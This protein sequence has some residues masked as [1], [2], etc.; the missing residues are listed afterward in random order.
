M[1]D[2]QV[3]DLNLAG[4][5]DIICPLL[6]GVEKVYHPTTRLLTIL[7]LL[8][9]RPILSGAELAQR[10]DVEPRTIRRYIMMLQ[11]MGMPVETVRGPGGGYQLRPG[12]K[13]PPLLFTE[14]EATA[15]VIGLLGTSSQ[16]SGLSA[17]PIEGALAKVLRVLP[18]RSRERLNAVAA[19]LSFSPPDHNAALDTGLLLSLSDAAQQRQR[20]SMTYAAEGSRPTSRTVEPYG[21]ARWWDQWYLVGYCC[22]RKDLRTFR[23]DRIQDTHLLVETFTRPEDFDCRAYLIEHLNFAGSRYPIKVEFHAPLA[24]VRGK[25]SEDYGTLT[26]SPTGTCFETQHGYLLA[27]AEYLASTRLQFVVITPPEL[28]EEL[29]A[30]AERIRDSATA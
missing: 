12:F 21:L 18:L 20:V 6:L 8:Q 25:V 29:L 15:I 5:E 7:E 26:A 10:L 17:V 27:V 1:G 22:L 13:L 14:E 2:K 23:L 24:E 4:V 3:V 28:R 11:D 16:V 30:L 9:I 19:N